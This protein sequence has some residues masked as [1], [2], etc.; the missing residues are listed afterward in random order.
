MLKRPK[1]RIT[2]YTPH[3]CSPIVHQN[4]RPAYS[5]SFLAEW[6]RQTVAKN[7]DT[8]PVQIQST[9]KIQFGNIGVNYQQVWQTQKALR[10]ELERD[11]AFNF[12]KILSLI[13][14]W[15]NEDKEN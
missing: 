11:E 12:R 4:F 8:L 2:R 15:K 3:T 1:F 10:I 6:Y 7:R 14:S 13:N 9:E 5:V